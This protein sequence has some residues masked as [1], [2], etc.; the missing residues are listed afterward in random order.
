M[1]WMKNLT[2]L[3]LER[4]GQSETFGKMPKYNSDKSNKLK[5]SFDS[6]DKDQFKEVSVEY[7]WHIKI[8]EEIC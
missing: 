2:S 6:M 7:F 1:G 8:A 3:I 5:H 4:Q